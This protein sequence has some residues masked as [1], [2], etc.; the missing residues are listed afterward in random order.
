M[1]IPIR[2]QLEGYAARV[3]VDKMTDQLLEDMSRSIQK[4]ETGARND[5]FVTFLKSHFEFHEC[6]L[7]ATENTYLIKIV[8]DL[9]KTTMWY[10][11]VIQ[12][13]HEAFDY[14]I[15]K[16][17]QILRFFE[18][19]DKDKAEKIVRDHIEAGMIRISKYFDE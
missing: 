16:H 12:Y 4:M 11:F 9:L 13:F 18:K 7:R 1:I 17:K 6:F 2:V 14:S 19:K 5:D 10:R 15:K 8:V 3:A